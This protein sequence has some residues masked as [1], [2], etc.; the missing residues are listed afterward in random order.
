MSG[1]ILWVSDP[2]TGLTS[3][4]GPTL[5]GSPSWRKVEAE[6]VARAVAEYAKENN[7][8]VVCLGD[9]FD[10]RRP[11]AWAYAVE[12]MYP[13]GS[14]C[15]RGNHDTYESIERVSPGEVMQS[16]QA[17]ARPASLTVGGFNIIALPWFGRSMLASDGSLSA[18]EQ[19]KMMEDYVADIISQRVAK[20]KAESD[21]KIIVVAH[22]MVAGAQYN[23]GTQPMLGQSSE[24]MVPAQVLA[25]PGVDAVF[26]GHVHK[27][28]TFLAGNVPITYVG[29]AIRNGFGDEDNVCRAIHLNPLEFY[30]GGKDVLVEY[31]PLPATEFVTIPVEMGV[32]MDERTSSYPVEGKVVRFKGNLPAGAETARLLANMRQDCVERGALRVAKPAITFTRHTVAREHT[33]TADNSPEETLARYFDLA[34]GDYAERKDELLTAHAALG[35]DEE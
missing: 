11:P 28:Q 25:Q 14:Y 12:R 20:A 10:S 32:D 4:D 17:I 31:V 27:P 6:R 21:A 24:F 1:G 3:H 13:K 15:L 2:H 19:Y 9:F 5:D 7:C 18:A 26:L 22:M 29:S 23:S 16:F 30:G 35:S 33:F 34:G 8:T